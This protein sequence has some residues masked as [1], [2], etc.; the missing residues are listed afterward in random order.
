MHNSQCK[1]VLLALRS[2]STRF[3]ELEQYLQ[4]GTVL[5]KVNLVNPAQRILD[6]V[7]DSIGI[8]HLPVFDVVPLIS[9]DEENAIP[10]ITESHRSSREEIMTLADGN[11]WQQ[12]Q[13]EEKSA[14]EP[15][16]RADAVDSERQDAPAEDIAPLTDDRGAEENLPGEMA[17]ERAVNRADTI[18][19]DLEE[20]SRSEAAHHNNLSN[21]IPNNGFV[22]SSYQLDWE[23]ADGVPPPTPDERPWGTMGASNTWQ[24]EPN[25]PG[26]GKSLLQSQEGQTSKVDGWQHA[27][28]A[29]PHS[30]TRTPQRRGNGVAHSIWANTTAVES[31]PRGPKFRASHKG[32]FSTASSSDAREGNGTSAR[33]KHSNADWEA[34]GQISPTTAD[35]IDAQQARCRPTATSFRS[36]ATTDKP[37]A[38]VWLDALLARSST[39]DYE[40]FSKAPGSKRAV[41]VNQRNQRVDLPIKT[42]TKE[43]LE[44][45]H[46][47]AKYRRHCNSHHL[48]GFCP[49]PDC[50]F[51]H[52]PIDREML[53]ALRY[54]ARSTPCKVG[55]GCRNPRCQFGHHCRS[56]GQC[57]SVKCWFATKGLHGI[58][59]EL[60]HFEMMPSGA[61]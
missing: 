12:G 59:P 29:S 60:D 57:R 10:T 4:D 3:V 49:L 37:V 8:A 23:V 61:S 55:S 19:A 30:S 41:P 1:Q 16:G 14:T 36:T 24:E 46:E 5:S 7:K 50:K 33:T 32:A 31:I 39:V 42:P 44:R 25:D 35:F 22:N 15:V 27:L 54:K 38:N 48:Y 13:L 26:R 52:S 20:P 53:T 28:P 51:L 43:A 47:D 11:S 58:D 40:S 9:L 34:T 56:A 21:S 6:F 45:F 2:D 18:Q 17:A